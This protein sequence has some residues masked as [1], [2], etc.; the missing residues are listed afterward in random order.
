ME[1]GRGDKKK[2]KGNT[3]ERIKVFFTKEQVQETVRRING[4]DVVD[5]PSYMSTIR[6]TRLA[7]GKA[8]KETLVP[9]TGCTIP[10]IPYPV[11]KFHGL[12]ISELD[13]DEP[14]CE[15]YGGSYLQLAGQTTFWAVIDGLVNR[16]FVK[17]LVV[18]GA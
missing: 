4:N 17:A 11:A 5:T 2:K 7:A 18:K 6:T 8:L 15:A 9:D 13:L 12:K 3:V 10:C 1:D 16:R 14:D